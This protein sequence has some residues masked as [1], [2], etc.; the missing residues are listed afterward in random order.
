MVNDNLEAILS[1]KFNKI[2]NE[3]SSCGMMRLLEIMSFSN[4]KTRPEANGNI[5][6]Y[7][8]NG[9]LS[10]TDKSSAENVI[11]IG[12]VGAY[13]GSVHIELNS[14]WVSDN[15]ISAKSLI[16]QDEYFDYFL[17]KQLD[18]YSSHIGT[19]QQL[20]TQGIL[21]QLEFP[22]IPQN[23]IEKFNLAAKPVFLCVINNKKEIEKLKKLSSLLL[24]RL[25]S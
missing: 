22:K 11:V 6:V 3:H 21:T 19:G 20:L 18:L 10:Y 23:E 8:G 7:G 16:S 15:A 4:G 1:L 25:A 14:C 24:S 5:P 9:I 12:R 13:C 17:L 2:Y